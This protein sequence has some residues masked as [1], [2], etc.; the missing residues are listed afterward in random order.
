MELTALPR[1]LYQALMEVA[2]RFDRKVGIMI[3]KAADPD[4]WGAGGPSSP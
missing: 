3:E 1:P 4:F 2:R